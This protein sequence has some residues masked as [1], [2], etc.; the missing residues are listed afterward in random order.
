MINIQKY[1][2][3]I[4]Y[5]LPGSATMKHVGCLV[6]LV[7]RDWNVFLHWILSYVWFSAVQYCTVYTVPKIS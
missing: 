4:L 1:F 3:D 7:G 2:A 6:K 5:I